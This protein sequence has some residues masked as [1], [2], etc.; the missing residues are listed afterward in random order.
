MNSVFSKKIKSNSFVISSEN[1]LS[2]SRSKDKLAAPPTSGLLDTSI[3]VASPAVHGVSMQHSLMENL[4]SK[5]PIFSLPFKN[6][7]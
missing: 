2:V 4:E 6:I 5:V 1:E 7:Y 3:S